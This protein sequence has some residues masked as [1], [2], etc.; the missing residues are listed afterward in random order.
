[1]V[2]LDFWPLILKINVTWSFWEMLQSNTSI[3]VAPVSLSVLENNV[4]VCTEF[5]SGERE[6]L[7]RLE[8]MGEISPEQR[9][10]HSGSEPDLG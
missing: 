7:G 1:M 8:F 3:T 4:F 2:S 10:L 5:A 9:L 6:R